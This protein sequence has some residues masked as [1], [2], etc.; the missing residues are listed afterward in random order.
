MGKAV[1]FADMKGAAYVPQ[2]GKGVFMENS[3][4]GAGRAEGWD[5]NQNLSKQAAGSGSPAPDDN[6]GGKVLFSSS[7]VPD[8]I[9]ERMRGS[10]YRENPW[11]AREDLQYLLVGHYGFDGRPRQGELIVNGRIAGELLE[12][13]GKLYE[14]RY[15]IEKMRLVDVYG[16]DDYASMA[17]NNTS[18]FNYRLIAGTNRLS[19]HS[20]GL[21]IDIN[22]RF[23]PYIR[24]DGQGGWIT[25]PAGSEEY[26]DRSRP[27]PYKL[28]ETDVCCRLFL[29]YGYVWGG[30]WTTVKD[31][32]HF[33]KIG[34]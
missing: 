21:A 30:H 14:Y 4:Q 28:E 3:Q 25:E 15:P 17:D 10:S 8:E 33:Q 9:F 16:G 11:I 7:P 32:Q 5:K 12:I 18:A 19:R 27:F 34:S 29:E 13:F 6:S 22:P 20:L 26:A 23:N 1:F 31:Y 24:P 2:K